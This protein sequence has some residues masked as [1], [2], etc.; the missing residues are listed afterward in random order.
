MSAMN[1]KRLAILLAGAIAMSAC[2]EKE[3]VYTP[4]AQWEQYNDQ[5]T[6]LR[7]THPLADSTAWLLNAGGNRV[8]IASSFE[9]AERFLD[10]RMEDKR[11]NDLDIQITVSRER[12]DSLKSLDE[13]V[14]TYVKE[15]S[16][17]RFTVTPIDTIEID[18]TDARKFSY[19]GNYKE[20]GTAK[21]STTRVY[22][23]RDS[24]IYCL[25]YAAFNDLFEPYS[26]IMDSLQ[27]SIRLPRPKPKGQAADESLPSI[28]FTEFSN[29]F[30]R[31]SYPDNFGA[32][33]PSVKGDTKFSL[34][35]KGYRQDCTVQIDILPAK[36]LTVEK[37]F[38]QNQGKFSRVAGKGETTVA[39]L[40]AMYL[41]YTPAK[42]IA[43]RAY[44]VVKNDQVYRII[45]NY[46]APKRNDFL[47]AFEKTVGSLKIS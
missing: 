3:K 27:A 29:N 28:T 14:N 36:G 40:K 21:V 43:S 32:N 13:I 26:S 15:K 17:E 30:L 33:T 8:T 47:P 4:I 31:I 5:F 37:V 12:S 44:F 1:R 18:S 23:I 46:F 38:D 19:I 39:G 9:A 24:V 16:I 22:A 25:E 10:P 6:G 34:L 42:D 7:F 41:N 45:V 2:G 11:E 35:I 20:D